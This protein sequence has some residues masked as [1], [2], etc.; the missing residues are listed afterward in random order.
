[1]T[2][3][4]PSVK[5]ILEEYPCF[6]QP[7]IVCDNEY[8]TFTYPYVHKLNCYIV[9]DVSSDDMDSNLMKVLKQVIIYSEIE[10]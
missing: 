5:L 3:D 6:E 8:Y 9:V 1:M 10:A 7:Q 4:E 2:S